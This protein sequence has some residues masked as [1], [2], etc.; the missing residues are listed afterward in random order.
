MQAVRHDVAHQV[1]HVVLHLGALGLLGW[2]K[3]RKVRLAT[4]T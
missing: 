1:A 4:A 3:K 2:H